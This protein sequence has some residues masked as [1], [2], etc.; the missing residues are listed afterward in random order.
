M[1]R[2]RTVSDS[3]LAAATPAAVYAVVADP[4]RTPEWSPENRGARTGGAGPLPV[5]AVFTGA[6]ERRG[7][8]WITECVVTA[9]EPGERFAFRVRAIGG[10][11]RRLRTRIATWE[12]RLEPAELPGGGSGTRV[13]QTWTDDRTMPDAVAR[14]F[15]AVATRGPFADFQRRNLATSLQRLK[16]VVETP[17]P[18]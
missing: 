11:R 3:V 6:N 9:A 12:H 8:R 1:A 7:F 13:T 16:A 15:D 17:T 18:A 10:A 4:T 14:V 2:Q 5:G